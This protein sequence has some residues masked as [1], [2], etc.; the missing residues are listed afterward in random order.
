MNRAIEKPVSDYS[1]LRIGYA[2]VSTDDQ[3]VQMQ[4]DALKRAGCQDDHIH[5]ETASG[6]SKKRPKLELA[7][8]DARPGDVFVVWKL[9]RLGRSM[10]DL[11]AK[12]DN[13]TRRNIGFVSITESIDT[14]TPAGR[15]LMHIMG[16]LSQFE[17]D[18]IVERTKAG[19]AAARARGVTIGHEPKIDM[20]K[21]ARMIAQGKTVRQ[22]AEHFDVVRSAVYQRF[23]ASARQQLRDEYLA[24]RAAKRKQE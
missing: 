1:G 22:V 13:L 14:T 18:L 16:A 3:S 4:V 15:L 7:L 23:S 6:V 5:V 11:L 19:Q 20:E 10:L 17:R 21:A 8:V 9:D 2:R 24:A 12:I